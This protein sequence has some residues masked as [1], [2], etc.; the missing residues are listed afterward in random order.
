M[1]EIKYIN[2]QTKI[3]FHLYNIKHVEKNLR[4]CKIVS[5]LLIVKSTKQNYVFIIIHTSICV[6]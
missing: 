1:Y 5:A 3:T 4:F 2:G 6:A